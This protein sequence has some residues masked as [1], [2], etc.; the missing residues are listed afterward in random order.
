MTQH[1]DREPFAY[2]SS[3]NYRG[4]RSPWSILPLAAV[5]LGVGVYIVVAP[6]VLSEGTFWVGGYLVAL[7]IAVIPLG[8]GTIAGYIGIR[9][10]RWMRSAQ[11]STLRPVVRDQRSSWGRMLPAEGEGEPG[12][13]AQRTTDIK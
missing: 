9:R 7:A 10:L 1:P 3:S 2:M 4:L 12:D 13:P 11:M 6:L 8:V 5:L